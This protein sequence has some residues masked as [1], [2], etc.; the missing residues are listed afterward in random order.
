[1]FVFLHFPILDYKLNIESTS[2]TQIHLIQKADFCFFLEGMLFFSRYAAFKLNNLVT[3]LELSLNK[4][5]LSL[6]TLY[7]RCV[8]P[9]VKYFFLTKC[10][11][12]EVHLTTT[13]KER[14]N[15]KC[16][17]AGTRSPPQR[18]PAWEHPCLVSSSGFPQ[19]SQY[20]AGWLLSGPT[21]LA[22]NRRGKK[23]ML[24]FLWWACS[25]SHQSNHI[26]AGY[27]KIKNKDN[28]HVVALYRLL[29]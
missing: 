15:R 12:K 9:L 21:L 1:M 19:R 28:N 17:W 11:F 6:A 18:S 7:H 27:K 4:S 10:V 13:V 24:F 5:K 25:Q 23:E 29:M 14:E 16:T 2:D 3:H 8:L 20:R 22:N 26:N